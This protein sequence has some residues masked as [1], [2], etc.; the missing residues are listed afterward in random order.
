MIHIWC[1]GL[2]WHYSSW[3]F[4]GQGQSSRSLT[5]FGYE[6]SQTTEK[7]TLTWEQQLRQHGWKSRPELETVAAIWKIHN[8]WKNVTKVVGATW[9]DDFLIKTVVCCCVLKVCTEN[10]SDGLSPCFAMQHQHLCLLRLV[11]IYCLGNT[12]RAKIMTTT[13]YASTT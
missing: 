1:A 4:K 11:S 6:C 7:W 2:S 10:K 3:M 12:Q 13:T 8:K 5:F 9:S